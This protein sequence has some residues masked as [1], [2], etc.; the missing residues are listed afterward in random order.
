MASICQLHG[1]CCIL[2][3][4]HAWITP[5]GASKKDCW[6]SKSDTC[7]LGALWFAPCDQLYVCTRTCLDFRRQNSLTYSLT[8]MWQCGSAVIQSGKGGPQPE[9]ESSTYSFS[10]RWFQLPFQLT[11]NFLTFRSLKACSNSCS[12]AAA[13]TIG[14]RS[15]SQTLTASIT[16]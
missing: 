11:C 2:L 16:I 6:A 8:C 3:A 14:R 10:R 7:G 1:Q 13:I 4:R 9:R 5:T 15:C 12:R